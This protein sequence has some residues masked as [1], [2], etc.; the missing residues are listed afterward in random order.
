MN[1]IDTALKLI[2]L[3][4]DRR[5]INSRIIAD[6]LMVSVRTAQR[7]LVA[8][9]SLP[10]LIYDEKENRYFIDENYKLN[11]TLDAER[12]RKEVRLLCNSSDKLRADICEICCNT[13]KTKL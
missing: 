7:Y 10:C 13:K 1:K 6:E 12:I 9:A 11:C 2:W 3:L 5:T 4:N 8:L